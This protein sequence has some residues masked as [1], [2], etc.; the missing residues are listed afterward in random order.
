MTSFQRVQYRKN[1]KQVT[2][3]EKTDKPDSKVKIN[4]VT[5]R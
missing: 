5:S 4:N 3:V 1:E 2:T